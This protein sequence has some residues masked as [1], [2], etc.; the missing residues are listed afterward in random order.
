MKYQ[1]YITT[2]YYSNIPLIGTGR[3]IPTTEHRKP[4]L[5]R[6]PSPHRHS[7]RCSSGCLQTTTHFTLQAV[8]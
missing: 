6:H 5:R 2:N 7:L 3:R 4:R 1:T 8:V